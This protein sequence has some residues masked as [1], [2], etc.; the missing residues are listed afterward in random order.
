M[1]L[2]PCARVATSSGAAE[3]EVSQT[4]KDSTLQSTEVGAST[5]EGFDGFVDPGAELLATLAS[6]VRV[7]A[8]QDH[9]LPIL[10][11]DRFVVRSALGAP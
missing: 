5:E 10:V 6:E 1:P 8:V 2:P 7:A 11:M 4:D 3:T 9:S